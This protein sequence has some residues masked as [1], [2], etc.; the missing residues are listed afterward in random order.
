MV[1]A[2]IGIAV[3]L[4]FVGICLCGLG[5]VAVKILTEIWADLSPLLQHEMLMRRIEVR[6][7]IDDTG[8]ECPEW[9]RDEEDE[10][11]GKVVRLVP[12]QQSEYLVDPE[13]ES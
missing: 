2:L 12:K 3:A 6:L 11:E 1:V 8:Y 10:D 7:M 5:L 9:L 13:G 4:F